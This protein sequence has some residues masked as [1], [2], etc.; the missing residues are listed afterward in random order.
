MFDMA[1]MEFIQNTSE[2]ATSLQPLLIL[3]DGLDLAKSTITSVFKGIDNYNPFTTRSYDVVMGLEDSGQ[4]Y[5]QDMI[6]ETHWS[7]WAKTLW[8][9]PCNAGCPPDLCIRK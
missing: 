7:H 5:F 1:I 3:S 2:W 6:A 9:D 8:A 4:P